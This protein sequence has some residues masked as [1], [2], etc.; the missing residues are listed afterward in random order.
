M[1]HLDYGNE[2]FKIIADTKSGNYIWIHENSR[3]FMISYGEKPKFF[4]NNYPIPN[5]TASSW[6]TVDNIIDLQ[7][8]ENTSK[9][10][11]NNIGRIIGTGLLFG[12]I[13]A[14]AGAIP[15]NKQKEK[16]NYLVR[17]N[18]DDIK[19]SVVDLRCS[20]I[21]TALRIISTLKLLKDKKIKEK[22]KK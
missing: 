7:L 20:D 8:I 21:T 16:T 6:Y 15:N 11:N 17:F 2:A 5:P 1:A 10:K 22:K 3:S 18:L 13:G 12:P 9:V 19:L 4:D 14:L